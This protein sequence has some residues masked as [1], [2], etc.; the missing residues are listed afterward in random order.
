MASVPTDSP[1]IIGD[2][3]DD[4]FARHHRI[5]WWDQQ[6]LAK[7]RV[8]IIGAGALGNEVVKNL[9]LLG[10]GYMVIADM[11]R[12]EASNLTRSVLF[13][14]SDEGMSKAQTAAAAARQLYPRTHAIPFDGNILADLGLGWFRW[15][16][17]IVGALDNREARLF[18]NRACAQTDRPWIDGGIDVL[19]GIVRGFKPPDTA[20]YECTM[21]EADWNLLNQR[22]SCSLLARK[23][24]AE[25]GVP[26]TITTASVVGAMQAQEV[27][28]RLHDLDHLDGTGFVFEGL[29][30]TS[31]SVN[32]DISPDCPWHEPPPQI[33][34]IAEFDSNTRMSRVYSWAIEQLGGCDA[35]DLSRELVLE[36]DC[37]GCGHK[38]RVLQPIDRITDD[39][40]LCSKCGA[41]CAPVFMHSIEP[42][43]D[44]MQLTA[45]QIGLPRWDVLW[46][47]HGMQILGVELAGDRP[48]WARSEA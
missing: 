33:H 39:Q 22:R 19:N 42:T 2:D 34:G 37:A 38:Q 4:R 6:K 35:I 48:D 10:V 14:E 26:T 40:A 13:R 1:L 47:R 11:D 41:E 45:Q 18:V 31:Y 29:R 5:A 17:V 8:I 16:E 15:A 12:I 7:A 25:G 28:K 24:F 44:L 27:L 46:V 3:A 36:L 23:A 32:Y 20:C 21:G 9:A 43:S 30:H